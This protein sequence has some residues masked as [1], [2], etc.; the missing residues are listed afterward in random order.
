MSVQ[1][2]LECL[3]LQRDS[4]GVLRFSHPMLFRRSIGTSV[5]GREQI[6]HAN[7]DL[8]APAP[9]GV[10]FLIGGMHG[11][12]IATV[13]LLEDFVEKH[14]ATV[15]T[16]TAVLPL[17]NPDGY[18]H[19]TRYNARG[20]DLNRNAGFSWRAD[21]TEPSG[22]APWSEPELC[23]LR[24]FILA[25]QPSK[26]VSL[27]WA[28]A[29]IDADGTQSTALAQAM[30][31]ALDENDRR[32]Y[33]LRV[34]ALGSGQRRL[35]E[36]YAACPGS[37]GQWCGYGLTYDDGSAPAMITLELPYD[38]AVE[39]RLDPLPEDHL[40][41]LRELFERE[42]DAYL[43]ATEGAVFKMLLAACRH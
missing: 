21:S 38:P 3:H 8:T 40:E 12:E 10:T 4:F 32:P 41:T 5:E 7:F 35:Q 20:V 25:V 1:N 28:L 22:P 43:R 13:L 11:D 27:H 29:E 14:L 6:V 26:I 34:T 2:A 9:R 23:A 19:C 31:S 15:A 17:C 18:E 37:L 42:A 33:R 36:I 39:T 24:D 16:P 30:W